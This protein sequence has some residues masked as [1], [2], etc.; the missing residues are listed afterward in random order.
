MNPQVLSDVLR[1]FERNSKK[2]SDFY[3]NRVAEI[4]NKI[5]EI[6]KIDKEISVLMVS[7]S[8]LAF[9]K[10]SNLQIDQIRQK[11]TELRNKKK[12]L[13]V[14]NN[15]P[16]NY[17]TPNYD[18]INC[19]DTG[20]K[21]DK[22]C[23]CVLAKCKV[24]ENRNHGVQ[25]GNLQTFE[26]F[27]LN[28]FSKNVDEKYGLSPFENASLNFSDLKSYADNFSSTSDNV[29][30]IGA[31]GLSKTHLAQSI[32]NVISKNGFSTFFI[33][34]V[35]MMELYEG[36]KFQGFDENRHQ[37]ITKIET[38]DF[39]VI[40]GLGFDMP[41]NYTRTVLYKIINSRVQNSK[42]ILI[43]TSYPLSKLDEKYTDMVSSRLKGDFESYLFFGEDIRQI[44]RKN[45]R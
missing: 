45:R 33:P 5:P 44:I 21:R 7:V 41:S 20:Y 4:S 39:L 34:A 28:Y 9:T 37:K 16:E 40:D 43:T 18:C 36:N 29:L 22:Y 6:T 12:T 8:K 10:S 32:L 17:L 27:N 30:L 15:F 1:E 19:N 13:L 25:N 42:P 26:T 14:K 3:D 23:D 35:D 2:K 24:L 38:C 11:V 31:N